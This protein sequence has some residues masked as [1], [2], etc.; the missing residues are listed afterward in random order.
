GYTGITLVDF[1]TGTTTYDDTAWDLVRQSDGKIVVVGET[2]NR[3]TGDKDFALARLTV[4]GG[5]DGSFDGDGMQTKHVE[6]T[7]VAY[8]VDLQTQG[9]NQGKIIISG[10]SRAQAPGS[11][12]YFSG[13]RF[14]ALDGS[15]EEKFSSG[16]FF[17]TGDDQ[18]WDVK[19]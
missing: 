18:A 3:T 11:K 17:S 6:Y 13:A 10:Y 4:A 12:A 19:V 5:L 2:E 8:G 1:S 9:V 7:D 16:Y 15:F 14:K